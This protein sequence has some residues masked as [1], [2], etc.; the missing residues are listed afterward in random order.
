MGK[1]RVAPAFAG[2]PLVFRLDDVRY[3][4]DFYNAFLAE[5]GDL[6][7]VAVA[8]WLDQ[9][10]P[11]QSAAQPGT[12]TPADLVL[13]ATVTEL[14]GDFRSGRTPAAVMTIQFTL[15]DLRGVSTRVRLE[16]TIGRRIELPE[17]SPA[18]LVR[19]YGHALGE[20]LTELVAAL[21]RVT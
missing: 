14:Y 21:R 11:F 15:L 12:R 6:M 17:A 13:E 3:A 20:I 18:A 4:A 7:G 9:A 19:G 16:Q 10:G 1:V 5:P 8:Q 2:R